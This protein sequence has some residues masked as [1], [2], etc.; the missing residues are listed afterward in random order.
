M[1]IAGAPPGEPTDSRRTARR[2]DRPQSIS[3]L[4]RVKTIAPA[5]LDQY[6]AEILAIVAASAP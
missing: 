5:K 3:Q 6:G 1:H 2:A 4:R